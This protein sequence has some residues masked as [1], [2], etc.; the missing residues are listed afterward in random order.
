LRGL[1][2]SD[3]VEKAAEGDPEALQVVQ[4]SQQPLMCC[5]S[6]GR[7]CFVVASF[8]AGTGFLELACLHACL[9]ACQ[10]RSCISLMLLVVG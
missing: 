5:C 7:A 10:Q 6:F 1:T 2:L 3:L 4:V 9:P 8:L